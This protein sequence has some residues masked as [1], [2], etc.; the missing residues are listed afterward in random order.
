LDDRLLVNDDEIELNINDVIIDVDSKENSMLHQSRKSPT[1][2]KLADTVKSP[3]RLE[4][5]SIKLD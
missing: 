1:D 2:E 3:N 5:N 4:P